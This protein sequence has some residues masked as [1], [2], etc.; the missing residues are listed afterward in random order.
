MQ[1]AEGIPSTTDLNSYDGLIIYIW[2]LAKLETF[3][4]NIV[5][6][7]K[8]LFRKQNLRPGIFFLSY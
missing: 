5:S 6:S 1:M 7:N 2:C 8:H 4:E 3:C